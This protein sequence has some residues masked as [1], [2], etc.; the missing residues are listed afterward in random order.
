M[1]WYR[2]PTEGGVCY[3]LHIIII[4]RFLHGKCNA[5]GLALDLRMHVCFSEHL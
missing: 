3:L 1:P 5:K 2:E 4:L